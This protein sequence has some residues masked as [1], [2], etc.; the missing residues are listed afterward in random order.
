MLQGGGDDTPVVANAVPTHK[1]TN[2]PISL[3]DNAGL[4]NLRLT[5]AMDHQ[6]H[7]DPV[8]AFSGASG[9]WVAWGSWPHLHR[10]VFAWGLGLLARD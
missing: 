10:R 7:S 9:S 1:V 8:A 5:V 2:A 4:S 3:E 6:R